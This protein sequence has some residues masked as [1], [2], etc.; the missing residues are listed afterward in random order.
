MTLKNKIIT[1]NNKI[2]TVGNKIATGCGSG[3]VPVCTGP[4]FNHIT[5]TTGT[6]CGMV[7]GGVSYCVDKIT[8]AACFSCGSSYYTF[9]P[10]PGPFTQSV[11]SIARIG[12]VNV[13]SDAGC[14][15]L[16]ATLDAYCQIVLSTDSATMQIKIYAIGGDG[17]LGIYDSD[18]FS[19]SD[20]F[21][22]TD[23][24]EIDNV[25]T[26]LGDCKLGTGGYL[27]AIICGNN[28]TC[29][30]QSACD[31]G[32]AIVDEDMQTFV[33]PGLDDE[34]CAD[35]NGPSPGPRIQAQTI[36]QCAG[37]IRSLRNCI[38]AQPGF[39]GQINQFKLIGL[40]D[41]DDPT[42][43]YNTLL[44]TAFIDLEGAFSDIPDISIFQA[45]Q[46]TANINA[47]DECF[48]ELCLTCIEDITDCTDC[49]DF[50]SYELFFNMPDGT[51]G[52][53]PMSRSSGGTN[54]NDG[55][56][57]REGG[58]GTDECAWVWSNSDSADG[59]ALSDFAVQLASSEGWNFAYGGELQSTGWSQS[60][61]GFR[62]THLAAGTPTC[63]PTG[64]WTPFDA[65]SYNGGTLSIS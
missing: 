4:V 61:M 18:E 58:V 34:G 1:V 57:T 9:V 28:D 17:Y 29:D 53:V 41:P 54:A 20:V 10:R 35:D 33:V 14:T 38:G 49:P 65:V 45:S 43:C 24:A 25:V 2:V 8:T 46:S 6:V 42:K 48:G 22:C 37:G 26:D 63:P 36:F 21:D 52:T 15:T 13:Y 19:P 44:V 47:E 60:G 27:V 7:V 31:S 23:P 59:D 16:T 56:M 12:G 55:I 30:C 40:V 64:P 50:Y 5:S 3:C 32:L 62:F 11:N 51:G 39:T